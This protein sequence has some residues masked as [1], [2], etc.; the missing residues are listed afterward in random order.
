M[1]SSNLIGP[2][3]SNN[4]SYYTPH[5]YTSHTR[6]L[7]QLIAIDTSHSMRNTENE[8]K[9]VSTSDEDIAVLLKHHELVVDNTLHAG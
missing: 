2:L 4:S 1:K 8:A 7:I 5:Y 6:I 9:F 3:P